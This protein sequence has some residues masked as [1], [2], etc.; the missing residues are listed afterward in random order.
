MVFG[1][2]CGAVAADKLANIV[3]ILHVNTD[4]VFLSYHE[5]VMYDEMVSNI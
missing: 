2:L 1:I 3:C 4:L 5:V